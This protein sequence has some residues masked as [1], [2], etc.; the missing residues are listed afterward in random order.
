MWTEVD[1]P[2]T[3]LSDWD[4]L[5][6]SSWEWVLLIPLS[7]VLVQILFVVG[8]SWF[9]QSHIPTLGASYIQSLAHEHR[10]PRM[11]PSGIDNYENH[12]STRAAYVINEVFVAMNHS[13]A[14]YPIPPRWCLHMCWSQR[15]LPVDFLPIN[16]HLGTQGKY[17]AC[18][19]HG[20]IYYKLQVFV[21]Y[22]IYS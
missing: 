3:S 17:E 1:G 2:K 5:S 4:S 18:E 15:E 14:I 7:W 12:T 10:R 16:P 22:F 19:S 21:L 11:I 20:M 13:S 6:P 9:T 8:E